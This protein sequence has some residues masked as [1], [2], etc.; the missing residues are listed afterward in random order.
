MRAR[1]WVGLVLFASLVFVMAR[2]WSSDERA[3]EK[4]LRKLVEGA[5]VERGEWP[6][7]RQARLA[8]LFDETTTPTLG[9]HSVDLPPAPAGRAA[10]GTW[11]QMLDQVDDASL[12]VVDLRIVVEGRRASATSDVTFKAHLGGDEW[13]DRR[14]VAW[15]LE[16]GDGGWRVRDIDVGARP[17]DWPEARP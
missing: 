1:A 16:K 11:A 5:H 9:V 10:L 7:V 13:T 17:N 3:V 12:E 2:Y 15:R 4:V 14:A 6:P 8:A